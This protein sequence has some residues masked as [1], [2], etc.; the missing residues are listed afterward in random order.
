MYPKLWDAS[1]VSYPAL[2]DRLI[3]LAMARQAQ[4]DRLERRYGDAA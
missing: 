2:M 4:K 1:G 3:G